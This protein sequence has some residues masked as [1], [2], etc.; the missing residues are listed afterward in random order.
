M[1]TGTRDAASSGRENRPRQGNGFINFTNAAAKERRTVRLGIDVPLLL[2]VITLMIFGL[3]MVYSASWDY[4]LRLGFKATYHFER[5]MIFMGLGTSVAV[6]LAFINYHWYRKLAV[7]GMV[8]VT[9]LLLLVLLLPDNERNNAVRSIFG[10]SVQPSEAAKMMIII[11]LSV[12]L[13]SKREQLKN[14]SFGLVPLAMILGLVGGLIL[15]QPDLSATVTIFILGGI[16]FFLA[17]GDLKQIVVLLA[18]ALLVGTV[19]VFLNATGSQRMGGFLPGLKDPTLAP[20][21]VQRAL[22][23]FVKGGWFGMGLGRGTTKLTGLPVPPTDSIFAV[24]GEELGVLGAVGLVALYAVLL[25]RGLEIARRAP[26]GLG[27]LLASGL[28]I[29]LVFEAYINMAVLV[30]L[31]PFAG[32]ALPFISAGGSNLVVS[33]AAIGILMNISRLSTQDREGEERTFSA[34]VDLRRGDRR[35]RVPRINRSD[36]LDG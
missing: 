19:V 21:H 18:L 3:L 17:G 24:V 26:D 10:G 6:V 28:C 34:V 22:E 1:V 20:Y 33:L 16:L 12:W 4:S 32:N 15:A 36:P 7:V 5:Q 31:L 8:L 14:V 35:R 23:A 11:Y 9:L 25:W 29:W 27:T 30:N 2:A 13:F